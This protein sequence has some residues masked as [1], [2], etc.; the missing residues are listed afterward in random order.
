MIKQTIIAICCFILLASCEY[1][2]LEPMDLG[3]LPTDVSLQDSLIPVFD[4]SCNTSGCHNAGGI[5]PDL[6]APNAYNAIV[7]GG[8]VDTAFPEQSI[9]YQRMIDEVKPMPPAGLLPTHDL[10]LVLGWI[11]EG[12]PDN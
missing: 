10:K 9:L 2:K 7:F 11:T 4:I 5:P 3:D 8:Y 12:A 6:T 1:E